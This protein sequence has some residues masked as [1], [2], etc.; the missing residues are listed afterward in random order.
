MSP[1]QLT[2]EDEGIAD[3][4]CR[5]ENLT[6]AWEG[7]KNIS[8][9]VGPSSMLVTDGPRWQKLQKLFNPAFSPSRLELFIPVVVEETLKFVK[10]LDEA[11]YRESV[12]PVSEPLVV[13]SAAG[14][15]R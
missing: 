5:V 4:V 6:K 2:R 3:R 13:Q 10:V 11:A 14:E 12:I 15:L 1:R 8:Q 9:V 7:Y